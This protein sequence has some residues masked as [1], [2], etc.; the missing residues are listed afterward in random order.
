MTQETSFDLKL[1]QECARAI[2][3]ACGV[4]CVVTDAAG[5]LYRKEGYG[6]ASCQLCLAAGR[7][8]EDC[9]R[10]QIYGMA[11]AARF[12]GKYIYFCP[13]GLTCF[14]SPILKEE[15]VTAKLTVGP[16]LMVD[17]QDFI[18]CDLEGQMGLCGHPLENVT[19]LLDQIPYIPAEKV[20]AMSDL[21]FMAVGFLN[22]VSA[23][24][25]ML[26][27]QGS[28]AIQS[29]IT[30]YIQQI[31]SDGAAR[32]YP[33]ETER[34]LLRAVR[35]LN[36][37]EARRRLN[38][39]LGYLFFSSGGDQTRIK[40]QIYELLILI[41]RAA[42]DAGAGPEATLAANQRYLQ[43][44]NELR[45]FDGLC[46]W[47]TKATGS[48]MDSV[49]DCAGAR[50]AS[51]IHQTVQYLNTHYSEKITM[52]K[53]ARR[54]YLSPSYFSRIFKEEMGTPFTAY[55][56]RVRVDRGKE[57]LRRKDI[58]L[59]DIAQLVG[60]EDQSYFTKVFKKQ[61]GI[62]PLRYRESHA[63]ELKAQGQGP[64]QRKGGAASGT[65]RPL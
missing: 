65:N 56:N 55:L 24:N 42:I 62:P 4:G 52:E 35:N 1:A 51:V 49:F 25:R 40:A 5:R 31:K 41:S 15:E 38:E 11:E 3:A 54:V 27:V 36:K 12:G 30:A 64:R 13:M 7:R 57:L 22:N 20:T 29:Q 44:I 8:P 18:A 2:S 37:G 6:C 53:M 59:T 26:E 9:V 14:V 60:F 34:A 45:D 48:L 10:S 16:F 46:V 33:L 63:K 39:L 50:H 21:L 17:R 43:D 23:A 47:F 58:R 28:T 32:P 61:E 19:A